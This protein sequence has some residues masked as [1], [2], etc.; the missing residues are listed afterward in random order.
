MIRSMLSLGLAS[1]F[2]APCAL[3]C[4]MYMPQ[5]MVLAELMEDIDAEEAPLLELASALPEPVA[6]A[7]AESATEAEQPTVVFLDLT[8]KEI[9]GAARVAR[10]EARAARR[11][12]K[13]G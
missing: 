2:L 13:A 7:Q 11:E 8:R 6:L 9:R 3:A 1:L 5:E 12:A 10:G 4:G